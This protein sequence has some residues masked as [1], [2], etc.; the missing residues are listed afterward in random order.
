MFMPPVIASSPSMA[1]ILAWFHDSSPSR[2][3]LTESWR[4]EPSATSR[5]IAFMLLEAVPWSTKEKGYWPK[6][7]RTVGG[8][9]FSER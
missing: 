6:I 1:T 9:S 3:R 7:M 8:D 5:V 4:G 2:Y